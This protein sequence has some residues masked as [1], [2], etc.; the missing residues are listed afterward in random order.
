MLRAKRRRADGPLS[1]RAYGSMR[2][3]AV[4][5]DIYLSK[6]L[7][8]LVIAADLMVQRQKQGREKE[9]YQS[10]FLRRC[11]LIK[12]IKKKAWVSGKSAKK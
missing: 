1:K 10:N 7:L 3:F 6:L 2:D 5:N 8:R 9:V 11:M 4:V 12:D